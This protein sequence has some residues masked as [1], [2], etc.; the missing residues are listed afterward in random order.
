MDG[1]PMLTCARAAASLCVRRSAGLGG[2]KRVRTCEGMGCRARG[3]RRGNCQALRGRCSR[4][5][6][7]ASAGIQKAPHTRQTRGRRGTRR[8]CGTRAGMSSP[9]IRRYRR[10]RRRCPSTSSF[11]PCQSS[12][13]SSGSQSTCLCSCAGLQECCILRLRARPHT[14]QASAGRA[15]HVRTKRSTG[16]ASSTNQNRTGRG[17]PTRHT[18]D[19]CPSGSPPDAH[20]RPCSQ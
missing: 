20:I 6:C 2:G 5:A 13:S 10:I 3:R 4:R 17:L 12:N 16:C 19:A 14:P 7:R 15:R 11:P 18:Q 1:R 8:A 9:S